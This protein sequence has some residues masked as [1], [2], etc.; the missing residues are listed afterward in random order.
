MKMKEKELSCLGSIFTACSM[1][2]RLLALVPFV[3]ISED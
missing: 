1:L 2:G 3:K